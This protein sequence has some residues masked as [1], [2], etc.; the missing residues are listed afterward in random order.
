MNVTIKANNEN[1]A[2][3]RNEIVAEILFEK[4]TPNRKEIQKAVAKAAKSDEKLTII[5][6]IKTEFGNSKAVVSAH[7]Y[8]NA[9]VMTKLE[10]KNLIE[11]HAAKE[12]PK[13][14][15]APVEEA[16]SEEAE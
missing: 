11:K 16:K 8:S 3:S 13:K 6:Q 5:N 15:E 14:E 10:R 9:D 7:V 12:E 1:K 2:L 4:A